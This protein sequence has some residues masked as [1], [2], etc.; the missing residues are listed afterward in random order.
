MGRGGAQA[1]GASLCDRFQEEADGVLMQPLS[2][3][4]LRVL[5][6]AGSNWSPGTPKP[7]WLP[8]DMPA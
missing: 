2:L 7:A 8:A 3:F 1:R 5:C 4:A 6:V